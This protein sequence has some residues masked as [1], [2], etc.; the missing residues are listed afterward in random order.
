MKSTHELSSKP[1]IAVVPFTNL[2]GDPEQ[3]YFSD[4]ITEDI[5][6][7]LSRLSGLLVVSSQS[8][9][10]Y[11]G[12]AVDVRQVGKEQGVH[13]VLQGSVRK[14]GNQVRVSVQLT[15][16]NIGHH[17]WVDRYDRDL[18][19]VFAVQDDIAHRITVEM[20]VHVSDGEKARMMAGRTKSVAAWEYLLRADELGN[21]YIRE[22]NLEARRLVEEALRHDPGYASAWTELGWTHWE[23][24]YC[25]WAESPDHSEEKALE[26]VQ[27]ALQLDQDYPNA[28][29]LLGFL[30]E[31]K[32]EYDQAIELT[33]RAVAFAPNNAENTAEFAHALTFAGKGKEAVEMFN[34]AIQL[35]PVYP[36]WYLVVLG[37]CY[38]SM[39]ELDLAINTFREAIAMEPGSAFARIYLAC[40]LVEVRSLEEAKLT[41]QEVM[42]IEQ[43]F[44]VT[45]W[46]G[47]PF[48]DDALRKKIDDNLM[49]AGLPR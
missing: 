13:Y 7:A 27:N 23:D 1:S 34:R 17:L 12:Q 2:S 31:L 40:A 10:V 35:S 29:S 14:S 9:R 47:S 28:L 45:R 11:K 42:D 5:I 46:K 3:E 32:G 26:A 6:T 39:K 33:K 44:S 36:V 41:A 30:H 38:Y 37:A 22:E 21:R 25:G 16:A 15:D 48:R 43:A 19:D 4:G 20:R 24:V 49:R 8:T 18:D